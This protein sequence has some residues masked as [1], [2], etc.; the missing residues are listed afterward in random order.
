M[1]TRKVTITLPDDLVDALGAA[2]RADGVPLSRLIAGA[3]E[4]ELRRRIG[5]QLVREWQDENGA[6]TPDEL[7]AVRAELAAADAAARGGLGNAAA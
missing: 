7:A 1:A 6:F 2:A 3:A 5:R 4:H